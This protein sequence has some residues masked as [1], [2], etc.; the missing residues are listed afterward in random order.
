MYNKF[1][2]LYPIPKRIYIYF[3]IF[4]TKVYLSRCTPNKRMLQFAHAVFVILKKKK[5][6]NVFTVFR[7]YTIR[8][9]GSRSFKACTTY[10]LQV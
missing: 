4:M 9:R 6:K 8:W 3:H 10:A 2:V 7:L 5:Q 1:G